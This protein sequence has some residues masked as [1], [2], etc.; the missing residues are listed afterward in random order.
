MDVEGVLRRQAGVI[1]R[2]QA[3]VVGLTGAQVDRRVATGRWEVLHPCV[4]LA[5]EP[6]Y[7]VEARVRS[8]APYAGERAT[9]TGV[10]TAWWDGPWPC[11]PD[12]AGHG[13]NHDSRSTAERRDRRMGA[14][15]LDKRLQGRS[16]VSGTP[17]CRLSGRLGMAR[18]RR[19]VRPRPAQAECA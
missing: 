9:V 6:E 16:R 2:A 8:T 19:T 3:T 12:T 1:G 10:A 14:R 11:P 18:R 5:A 17:D 15:L 7:I 13:R 4:Y